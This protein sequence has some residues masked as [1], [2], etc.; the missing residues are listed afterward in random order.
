MDDLLPPQCEIQPLRHIPQPGGNLPDSRQPFLLL[1][2]FQTAGLHVTHHQ[3]RTRLI[4][5]AVV[6]RNDSGVIHPGNQTSLRKKT[7]PAVIRLAL[8]IEYLHRHPAGQ[9]RFDRPVDRG[10][11]TVPADLL[12]QIPVEPFR[13]TQPG[14]AL[15]TRKVGERLQLGNVQFRV[16]SAAVDL[17]RFRCGHGQPTLLT[18]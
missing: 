12:Q 14:P 17:Q 16:T 8:R 2:L 3:K 18:E 11:S 4:H 6:D 15:R 13:H 10:H 1:P 5:A 7:L 9:F